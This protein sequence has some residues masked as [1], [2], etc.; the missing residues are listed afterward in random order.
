FSAG[1]IAMSPTIATPLSDSFNSRNT[2]L[3][4]GG[5][6]S[7]APRNVLTG[8]GCHGNVLVNAAVSTMGGEIYGDVGTN[9]GTV[10]KTRKISGNVYNDVSVTVPP[11]LKP[12]W[13]TG[14]QAVPGNSTITLPANGA[15]QR[16][17]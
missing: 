7:S 4:P 3:W 2:A 9:G 14:V 16:Y 13:T 8:V 12:T 5:L 15:V 1:I 11:V 6:Y 17:K 10:Q